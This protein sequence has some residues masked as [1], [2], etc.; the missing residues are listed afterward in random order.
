MRW[1]ERPSCE[2][3]K[4]ITRDTSSRR[5]ITSSYAVRRNISCQFQILTDSD[6]D[7]NHR[8]IRITV[9]TAIVRVRKK[10]HQ[11]SFVKLAR[12]SIIPRGIAVTLSACALDIT[13]RPRRFSI[14]NA[15]Q[16]GPAGS[17]RVR[18]RRTLMLVRATYVP[19]ETRGEVISVWQVIPRHDNE[20]L[21]PF[22]C[23]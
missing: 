15:T 6:Y 8:A 19:R 4:N 20:P 23:K 2:K 12:G 9:Y 18:R 14:A 22:T 5:S 11:R 13:T 21:W 1:N 10:E 16:R 17:E 7:L 3:K